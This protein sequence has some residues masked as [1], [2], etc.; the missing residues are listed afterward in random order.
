MENSLKITEVSV[1][2]ILTDNINVTIND[3]IPFLVDTRPKSIQRIISKHNDIIPDWISKPK[4]NSLKFIYKFRLQQ[5]ECLYNPVKNMITLYKIKY[6][7]YDKLND[8]LLF[9]AINAQPIKKYEIRF[10]ATGQLALV[11]P[12]N[13]NIMADIIMNDPE[14]FS[15]LALREKTHTINAS[16]FFSVSVDTNMQPNHVRVTLTSNASTKKLII[17]MSKLSNPDVAYT[18]MSILQKLL[19]A[20]NSQYDDL[21]EEYAEFS[22]SHSTS[23]KRASTQIN[24]IRN[25]R[26]KVP[27]LFI[28]N[29][30]RECPILPILVDNL[31]DVE[32]LKEKNQSI[33]LYPPTGQYSRY[34]TAP[35]DYYVGLKK[36]RL[37]NN[38]LFPYL[39]TCY[40]SDHMARTSSIT[41]KYYVGSNELHRQRSSIQV[42][43]SLMSR[44]NSYCRK[45]IPNNSFIAALETALHITIET[46]VLPSC[47]QI[48]KQ[49][50]WDLSDDQIMDVVKNKETDIYTIGSCVFR[51][52]EELFKISIHVV[53]INNGH[54]TTLIPRHKDVYIWTEPYDKHVVIFE[55]IRKIYN[56]TVCV[57]DILTKNNKQTIFNKDDDIV[58]SILSQKRS[59]S[60]VPT[61]VQKVSYQI[62]D[63]QGKCRQVITED[64][65]EQNIYTRPLTVPLLTNKC[66]IEDHVQKMNILK[67]QFSIPI[68]D[69]NKHSTYHIK[70]FPNDQSY[71]YWYHVCRTENTTR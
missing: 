6:E 3:D 56:K 62:I 34:Y 52:F 50:L 18:V 13:K 55:N 19:I 23:P 17:T 8:K 57:Y 51:Y 71:Q 45:K 16:R 67:T 4:E 21:W 61:N 70:Y 7:N 22:D 35:E 44:N 2:Y 43:R 48:T 26:S 68:I 69:L 14:I 20:Y 1:S 29:Y 11:R 15:I 27:E 33:I 59:Q 39:V 38:D 53:P 49:E 28:N 36:N 54:I 12:W 25:L 64:K 30:T 24:E 42:P 41:Y 66:F 46:S 58:S 31:E 10:K 47:P 63:E 32:S 5:V 60:I 65:K 9:D 40:K 37:K